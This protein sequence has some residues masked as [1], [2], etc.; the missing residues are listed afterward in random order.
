MKVL[1]IEDS[2]RLRRSIETGLKK[3]GFAVDVSAD[4]TDGLWRA[5]NHDYDVI[6]L[7]NVLHHVEPAT[8]QTV[9]TR[10][11]DFMAPGGRIILFE[12]NPF[13]PFTRRVVKH[14]PLDQGVVLLPP[15]E[16]I[17]YLKKSAFESIQ[18]RYIVFFP[19]WLSA[20][21]GLESSLSWL[22][23]GAQYVVYGSF[24]RKQ[25]D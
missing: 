25:A 11:R 5:E 14:S 24:K 7:A 16:T 1:L 23:L 10:L 8:R 17:S 22:S 21:R 12:H 13:N 20:L 18:M 19:K 6:V 2:E 9:M 15:A 3:S 4:G